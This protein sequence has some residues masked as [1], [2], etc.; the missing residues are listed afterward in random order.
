MR[1]NCGRWHGHY[2]DNRVQITEAD[3]KPGR[4][5]GWHKFCESGLRIASSNIRKHLLLT[6]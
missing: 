5:N 4:I 6:I 2:L 1:R 3:L